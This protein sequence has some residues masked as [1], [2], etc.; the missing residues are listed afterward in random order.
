MNM[1][2]FEKIKIAKRDRFHFGLSASID[3]LN[4]F[5]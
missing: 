1:I 4:L 2:S 3:K 5:H